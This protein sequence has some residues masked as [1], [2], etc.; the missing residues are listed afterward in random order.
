M[1]FLLSSLYL[2]GSWIIEMR[3]CSWVSGC[4]QYSP[5]GVL[6]SRHQEKKGDRFSDFYIWGNSRFSFAYRDN[7]SCEACYRRWI[8]EVFSYAPLQ[9]QLVQ[10][11]TRR[12]DHQVQTLAVRRRHLLLANH[13]ILSLA[14]I[15]LHKP[16]FL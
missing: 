8:L 2:C 16:I 3:L 10:K 5:L 9:H 1:G 11:R 12:T 15:L 14:L 13:Y 4:L 7:T 6:C